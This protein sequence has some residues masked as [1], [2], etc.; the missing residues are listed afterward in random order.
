MAEEVSVFLGDVG[1]AHF[2]HFVFCV[3]SKVRF[4]GRNVFSDEMSV[5]SSNF[6][7]SVL[8]EERRKSEVSC[9]GVH[10]GT[11]CL[12]LLAELSKAFPLLADSFLVFFCCA[13]LLIH[14][15]FVARLALPP[16]SLHW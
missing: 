13:L 9:G 12:P 1:V 16:P 3:E 4:V 7:Q 11:Q 2:E 5:L 15:A 8:Q 14:V 10:S 6:L